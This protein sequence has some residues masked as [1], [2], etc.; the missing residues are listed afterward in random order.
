MVS[1]ELDI[2]FF[3]QMGLFLFLVYILNVLLYKPVL[4]VMEERSKKLTDLEKD[5][6]S[7]EKQ[8]EEKLAEYKAKLEVA[9]GEGNAER[10]KLKKEGLDKETHIL[11]EAHAAAQASIGEA[12]ERIAKE[13]GAALESLRGMVDEMGHAISDKVIGRVQ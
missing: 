8:V 3:I 10:G 4:K 2:T 6:L 5:A 13:K 1:I 9:R 7:A 12:I 11:E